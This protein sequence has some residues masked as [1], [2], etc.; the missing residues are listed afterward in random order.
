MKQREKT[1]KTGRTY[2]GLNSKERTSQRRQRFLAAGLKLFGTHGFRNATVRKLCKEAQLT[3]RYFY[4][5][6]SNLECVLMEVYEG[7]MKNLKNNILNAISLEYKK[8]GTE[9]AIKAGLEAYFKEL[10]NPQVARICMVELEGIS[11]EVNS[12]YYSYI[13]DFAAMLIDLAK[14]AYPNW[15]LNAEQQE[16]ISISLIGAMRQTATNWLVNDYKISR[17]SLVFAT[18]QLFISFMHSIEEKF[19]ITDKLQ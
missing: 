7:C 11:S 4:E 2:A 13:D 16:I 6:F 3:D 1:N 18:S 5:S 17:D 12:L 10:E 9:Q 19:L 14:Y 8:H 15:T